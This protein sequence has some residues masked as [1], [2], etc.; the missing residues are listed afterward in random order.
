MIAYES[1]KKIADSAGVKTPA[2]AIQTPEGLSYG[3]SKGFSEVFRWN[4]SSGIE[5]YLGRLGLS[6]KMG[7]VDTGIFNAQFAMS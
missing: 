6:F 4:Y 1:E 5:A 3:R 2:S 7:Y